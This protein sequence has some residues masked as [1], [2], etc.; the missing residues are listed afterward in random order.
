MPPKFST[1]SFEFAPSDEVPDH[2]DDYPSE[3]E[4]DL[5]KF[6]VKGY[7][8]F[9][10]TYYPLAIDVDTLAQAQMLQAARRRS[11]E[12]SQPTET[13]GGQDGI[14]DGVMIVYPA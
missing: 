9:D 11:L 3:E 4:R 6:Y 2:I 7:D 1:R 13:S 14:Q 5:G 10:S 8:R 12:L